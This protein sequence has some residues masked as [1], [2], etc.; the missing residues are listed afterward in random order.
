[1]LDVRT[2]LFLLGI[3]LSLI[4]ALM[5]A[6]LSLDY[7]FYEGHH[8]QEF[9]VSSFICGLAGTLLF[10]SN[11]PHHAIALGVR[12][13]FLFTTTLWI[14]GSLVSSL[15][16]YFS[17][18]HIVFT[19]ALFE[20]TSAL[21]TTGATILIGLDSMPK[22][23]L[24]WRAML[25]WLGGIGIIVMAMIIFPILRIGGMHLFRSE[26]S[27]RSEKIL[28]RVSQIATGIFAVYSTLT[29]LC[30]FFL[31]MAGM[32]FF[33]AVCH[34]MATLSTGGLSTRDTSIQAFH[35]WQIELVLMVFMTLGGGTLIL[36]VKAWQ[37]DAQSLIRDPQYR[38]YLITLLLSGTLLSLWHFSMNNVTFLVALRQGF[39][40]VISITTTTGFFIADYTVWGSFPGML[41]VILGMIGG[42]TGSTSGGIKIF[43]VQIFFSFALSHLRQLRRV[44][45]VYIPTFKGQKLSENIS[46]SIFIF[47]TLYIM[48]TFILALILS[49]F[50]LDF[51]TAFTGAVGAMSNLGVGVGKVIGPSGSFSSLTMGPKLGLMIG[52]LLGRLELLTIL[53]LFL[54][55]FWK[56]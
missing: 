51:T 37:K 12:E 35:S 28:P 22:S 44:H 33:N 24:L 2:V 26:F 43:R 46:L 38:V 11:Q 8:W 10:V 42:C 48:C 21:T 41:M 54:P 36:Y 47:M 20:A 56:N 34:S 23:I 55:S 13:A 53:V 14:V 31:Y 15:P 52:M 29:L 3:L 9:A 5:L 6:P 4:A 16:F 32:D 7:F 19:D 45:G 25:Q 1:M 40:S 30:L 18:L 27:D 17:S 50:D 49:F 39:F